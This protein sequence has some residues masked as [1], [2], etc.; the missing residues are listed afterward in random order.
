MPRFATSLVSIVLPASVL[1]D[2]APAVQSGYQGTDLPLPPPP[3]DHTTGSHGL[4]GGANAPTGN[5][6]AV[7]QDKGVVGRTLAIPLTSVVRIGAFAG[8]R[9]GLGP[10]IRTLVRERGSGTPSGPRASERATAREGF[11]AELHSAVQND[12]AMDVHLGLGPQI[13]SHVSSETKQNN[14]DGKPALAPFH[15]ALTGSNQN[16]TLEH[17]AYGRHGLGLGPQLSSHVHADLSAASSAGATPAGGSTGSTGSTG[18]SGSSSSSSNS[19]SKHSLELLVYR[20]ADA[21]NQNVFFLCLLALVVLA[22][23][24]PSKEK[25]TASREKGWLVGRLHW[26]R[27]AV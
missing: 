7:Q 3:L 10:Q 6:E 9:L 4:R 16:E 27:S 11:T 12:A 20:I 26:K 25:K 2:L 24:K 14:I 23:F 18:S 8:P 13:S 15:L 22:L 5:L 21:W 19:S 1:A 17:A